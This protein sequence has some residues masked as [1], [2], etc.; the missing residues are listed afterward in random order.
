GFA[1]WCMIVATTALFV[2]G[3]RSRFLDEAQ[4]V[5]MGGFKILAGNRA[6]FYGMLGLCGVQCVQRYSDF[7]HGVMF[8]TALLII[9]LR[10]HNPYPSW[11]LPSLMLIS[12][13]VKSVGVYGS[14]APKISPI[15]TVPLERE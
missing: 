2:M 4:R 7:T 15:W 12:A 11:E 3:S 6:I 13:L 1:A 10:C 5:D 9:R 8:N 14:T